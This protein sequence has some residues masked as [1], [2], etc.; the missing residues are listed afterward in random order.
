MIEVSRLIVG[1]SLDGKTMMCDPDHKSLIADLG[2]D[3]C[4]IDIYTLVGHEFHHARR[5]V[6]CPDWGVGKKQ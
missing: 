2:N 4:E 5:R 1:G 3:A 6:C